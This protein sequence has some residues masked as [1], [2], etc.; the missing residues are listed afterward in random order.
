LVESRI[1]DSYGSVF[2][3]V[4]VVVVVH[5]WSVVTNLVW[6]CCVVGS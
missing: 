5:G 1:K 3:V 6:L 2:A 4:V